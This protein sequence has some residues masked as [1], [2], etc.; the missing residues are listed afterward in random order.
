MASISAALPSPINP[1]LR[2]PVLKQ[3]S[4]KSRST[5]Y[6]DIEKGLMTK[7][8][9]IGGGC[10]A[11]PYNEVEALNK[12]RIA[13]KSDDEIKALVVQLEALRSA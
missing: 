8:V 11:W 4:G 3:V 6:R 2:L 12:A 1:L 7:P 9:K 10:S 5:V 13:G